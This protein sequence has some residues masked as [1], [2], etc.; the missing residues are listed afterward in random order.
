MGYRV[1]K[2]TGPEPDDASRAYLIPSP[3]QSGIARR[4]FGTDNTAAEESPLLYCTI[5]NPRLNP[6]PVECGYQTDLTTP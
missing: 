4:E 1:W 5:Q 3:K 2:T 6:S